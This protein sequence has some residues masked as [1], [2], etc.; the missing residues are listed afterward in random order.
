MSAD[1]IWKED[2]R[3]PANVSAPRGPAWTQLRRQ[4]IA[5]TKLGWELD[6]PDGVPNLQQKKCATGWKGLDGSLCFVCRW[7]VGCDHKRLPHYL[8]EW[9]LRCTLCW[10]GNVKTCKPCFFCFFL[11][12]AECLQHMLPIML[13]WGS[14]WVRW[15]KG[16]RVFLAPSVS[17]DASVGAPLRSYVLNMDQ[18]GWPAMEHSSTNAIFTPRL[19]A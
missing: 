18:K 11:K 3:R 1:V 16:Q 5:C 8:A 6:I 7:A 13:L 12:C 15:C 10:K 2:W 9:I 17:A 14:F 19:T 4:L